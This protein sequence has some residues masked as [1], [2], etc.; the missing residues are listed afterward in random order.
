MGRASSTLPPPKNSKLAEAVRRAE[1][2]SFDPRDENLAREVI[3]AD[4]I[5]K[6][7]HSIHTWPFDAGIMTRLVS[8]TAL[9]LIITVFGREVIRIFLGL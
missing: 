8:I 3:T 7:I 6:E 9:P 4:V 1:S 5:R 2:G